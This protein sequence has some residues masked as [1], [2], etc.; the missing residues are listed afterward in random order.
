MLHHHPNENQLIPMELSFK[1]DPKDIPDPEDVD[2]DVKEK[3]GSVVG[4]MIYATRWCWPHFLYPVNT[5]ARV[6]HAPAEKHLK[7]AYKVLS[8]MAKNPETGLRFSAGR[9]RFEFSN[10]VFDDM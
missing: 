1:I 7:A 8:C 9:W 5:L 3:F 6:L 4:T 10:R 2:P